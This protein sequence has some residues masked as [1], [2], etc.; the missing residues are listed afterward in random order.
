MWVDRIRWARVDDPRLEGL[1]VDAHLRLTLRGHVLR[2]VRT[3]SGLFA[4]EDRCPHQGRSFEGGWCEE[5]HLVCP[6]HRFAFDP[7]TGRARRGSTVNVGTHPVEQRS[8]GLYIGFPYTTV[9]LFGFD[10]W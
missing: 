7:A 4:L 3:R 6:W 2:L 5:G 8:D 10:L 9:R 1:P